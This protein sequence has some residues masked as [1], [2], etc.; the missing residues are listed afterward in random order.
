MRPLPEKK[1]TDQS[2]SPP[3]PDLNPVPEELL[4]QLHEANARF[5]DGREQVEKAME[6]TE[7]RHQERLN[8]AEQ[9]LR[10]AEEHVEEVEKQIER[11]LNQT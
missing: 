11:E 3:C 7:Y 10:G 8:Q 4:G 6:G 2:T 5:H 1:M 9:E